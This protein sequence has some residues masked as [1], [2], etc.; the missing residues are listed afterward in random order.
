M[1]KSEWKSIFKNKKLLISVIAVLFIPVMYAGMF[2]WAFWDPYANLSDLPVAVVNSDEGAEFNG[3]ELSLGKEL[4]DKLRESGQFKFVSVSEKEAD[5]GLLNQDYYLLIEIPDNFSAHATTLLD[6]KP[7]KMVITYKANEGYNFLSSQIGETA[8]DRIRAEVNEQVSATYAEQLFDSITKLGDGFAEASDGAGQ[9]KDGVVE[10]NNG[11][12][13]LKGYLEQLAS[14]TIELRDG[15]STVVEGIQSA[16]NGS[17]DLNKGLATLADGS[18]QLTNGVSQTASGATALNSGIQDYTA[19][20]DKLNESYQLLSEKEKGLLDSLTKL[21]ASSSKLNDSTNQLAQGSANVTAGI[22][23]LSQQLGQITAALPPEQSAAITETLAKLEAGSTSVSSGLE[24]LAGG[25][26][27]LTSGTAQIVSGAEQLSGGYS[28]AQQGVSKLASSSTALL[29]GSASLAGGTK[30]L[31]EKMNEFNAGINQAYSGSSSL[32]N[33]LNELASGSSQLKEGTGTLAEKSGELAD[34]STKLVEGTQLLADGTD[35]LQSS[36]KEASEQAGEVNASES[37]YEMVA[38]PVDVDVIG[39]NEVPNYGTGFTPYF[40]SLGLF[41]GA[42]LISIVFPFVQPVIAPTSGAK[43]FTSKVTVLGAVGIIQSLFVVAV[44]L[45][46]LKLETQSVGLFIL[47]AV[48]TS[49]TYLALIQLLVSILGDPGRFVAI[50]I[51]ILQLTTSAG[52]FPLELIPAPLQ[53]F[54]KLLPMTYSVQSFKASI[55]TG[56]LSHF[57]QNNS[58]LLGFMVVCLAI[59][60]GYFMLLFAKRYSKQP[61]EA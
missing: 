20:V 7:E 2:L 32:V 4:T 60:F 1:I 25:T 49:F 26:K 52:T 40:L 35:T 55:S 39:V 14:S 37:T 18:S 58:F 6:E 30:T 9:L 12:S 21:Q 23:A 50:V 13:N 29:E 54:N 56:D 28:Q 41:V 22:Q 38:S 10:V 17:V 45:F 24:Q 3:T 5:E 16:A 57:W 46:V 11:A 36:L 8:M 34:G 47:S 42:L 15:T 53:F 61:K 44:A 33:G 31:E 19:G 51:L 43:W 59:T 27:N 48:I